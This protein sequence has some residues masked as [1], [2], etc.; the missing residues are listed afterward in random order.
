MNRSRFLATLIVFLAVTAAAIAQTP[1][2]VIYFI[3]DGMGCNQVYATQAYNKAMGL[4]PVNFYSFPVRALITTYSASSLVTDSSAA[5]TALSTGTKIKNGVCG[6]DMA[7]NILK[8]VSEYAQEKGIGTGVATTVGINHA[9]PAAFYGHTQSRADYDILS[10]QLIDSKMDFA[11]GASFIKGKGSELA[12]KDWVA[13]AE[14]AGIKVFYGKDK[15]KTVKGKRVICLSDNIDVDRLE[16]AI[17]RKSGQTELADFTAAG[18]DYLYTNFSKKGFVFMVEG[19]KIDYACHAK[20]AATAVAEV[21]DLAK[22]VQLAIDFYNKHPK[23]TLIIVTADHETGGMIIGDSKYEVRP[24]ILA[25]QKV[26]KDV[27]TAA[28]HKLSLEMGENIT[29]KA[30]KNCLSENLG[31][32]TSVPVSADQEKKFTQI[33]KEVYLDSA[34]AS[35]VNLYSANSKMAVAAVDFLEHSAGVNYTFGSHSGAPLMIYCKGASAT[36]FAGITDNTEVPL[37]IEKLLKLR[38]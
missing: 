18:L 21:N 17:D 13:K 7:G 14:N 29:W 12:P 1:K 30:V 3:G 22:S 11:A 19:G 23:E 38:K 15:Y 2:Y 35:E 26:S 33:F 6:I 4:E 5:G 10:Q 24:E 9:T 28:L 27:L 32:W 36:S 8:T 37:T 16:Y 34:D 31:L 25:N 20:D